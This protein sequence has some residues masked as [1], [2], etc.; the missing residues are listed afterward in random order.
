MT[1][2][3]QTIIDLVQAST[4]WAQTHMNTIGEVVRQIVFL[5]MLFN[6]IALTPE[7]QI[8]FMQALSAIVAAIT[9]A[10]IVSKNRVGERIDQEVSRRTGE[11]GIMSA[12]EPGGL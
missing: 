12:R 2:T 3:A 1:Q 5:L 9:G 10:N 6:L 7:Q 8:G 4:K 11:S